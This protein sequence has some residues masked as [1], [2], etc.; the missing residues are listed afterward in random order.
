MKTKFTLPLSFKCALAAVLFFQLNSFANGEPGNGAKKNESSAISYVFYVK[1]SIERCRMI[2]SAVIVLDKYDLTG[3]GFIVKTVAIGPNREIQLS[4]IPEGKYYASIYTYGLHRERVSS[5]ITV[6]RNP[7][8]KNTN[9]TIV[10][11]NEGESYS[12]GQLV[13]PAEDTKLFAYTK[14]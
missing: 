9:Q 12:K 6:K 3:A 13:I 8:K 10:R 1:N 11:F 2:D 7:K 4:D 5:V 14:F